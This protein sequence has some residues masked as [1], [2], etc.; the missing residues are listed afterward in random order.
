MRYKN[1][2]IKKKFIEYNQLKKKASKIRRDNII[3]AAKEEIKDISD[4]E[5]KLLGI[6]LYWAEGK[7]A[8]TKNASATFTNSDGCMIKLMMR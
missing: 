8:S 7:K 2:L 6:A 4:S 5:L 1:E 3:K